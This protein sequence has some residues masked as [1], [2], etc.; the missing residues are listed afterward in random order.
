MGLCSSLCAE[1]VTNT[2]DA[3]GR[4]LLI[5]AVM[6]QNQKRVSELIEARAD[7][8]IQDAEGWTAL[9]HAAANN[10]EGLVSALLHAGADVN[11]QDAEGWIPLSRAAAYSN[12]K[13]I[14]LSLIHGGAD[15]NKQDNEGHTAL[16]CAA[17]YATRYSNTEVV[18]LLIQ[19]GAD[20]NIQ[21]NGGWTPLICAVK[22]NQNDIVSLFIE[23]GADLNIKDSNGWTPLVHAADHC[24]MDTVSMSIATS[25]IHHG[26]DVNHDEFMGSLCDMILIDTRPEIPPA[27]WPWLITY[28]SDVFAFAMRAGLL[29]QK[30]AAVREL[31][32]KFHGIEAPSEH[33]TRLVRCLLQHLTCPPSLF[34]ITKVAIR[35]HFVKL[36]R[37]KSIYHSVESLPIPQ[38]LITF[39]LLN[40]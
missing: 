21:D 4:T 36:T 19:A 2:P 23:A 34:D 37:G 16:Y 30:S 31:M 14:V 3:S 11:V 8:N 13:E 27:F 9:S 10:R 29:P 22:R 6:E 26:A 35:D 20:V 15:V 1:H 32:D 28:A 40:D 24:D 5:H 12:N 17:Y 25:L 39:I 18:S 7:L 38:A 33:L